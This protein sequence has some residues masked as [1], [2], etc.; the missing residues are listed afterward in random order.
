MSPKFANRAADALA[1][2]CR[3]LRMS[4]CGSHAFR[5]GC[6]K[7]RLLLR[8]G[9]SA[10]GCLRPWLGLVRGLR[11]GGEELVDDANIL[12]CDGARGGGGT[13]EGLRRDKRQTVNGGCKRGG[14]EREAREWQ[15]RIAALT[16]AT[17]QLDGTHG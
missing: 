8:I 1:V 17:A 9:L 3:R 10:L 13:N 5:E 4:S 2:V 14:K 6:A 11:V 15:H 16:I 12:G 7:G